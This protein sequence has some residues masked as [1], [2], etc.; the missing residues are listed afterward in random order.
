VIEGLTITDAI[1]DGL[2]LPDNTYG[3]RAVLA[4]WRWFNSLG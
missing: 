2:L 4:A 1:N 3:Q